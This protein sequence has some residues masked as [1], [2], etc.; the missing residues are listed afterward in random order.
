VPLLL[1]NK[2]YN[3]TFPTFVLDIDDREDCVLECDALGLSA[4]ASLIVCDYQEPLAPPIADFAVYTVARRAKEQAERA[5]KEAADIA[6]LV[7]FVEAL[8]SLRFSSSISA[9]EQQDLAD[10][11]LGCL[12]EHCAIP[13]K[14]RATISDSSADCRICSFRR[15]GAS[16]CTSCRW[17][18]RHRTA[19]VEDGRT[20]IQ[21]L[22]L[23]LSERRKLHPLA[24]LF[25]RKQKRQIRIMRRV[26]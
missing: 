6:K 10:L 20:G 25:R 26:G 13:P 9:A 5:K 21:S 17:G 2:H 16:S 19:Q 15:G 18:S 7:A 22:N 12:R 8:K 11:I 1:T 4:S 24:Q 3:V 23:L 14:L